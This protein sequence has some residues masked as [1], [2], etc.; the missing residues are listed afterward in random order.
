MS[1]L[2]C[3]NFF[4]LQPRDKVTDKSST[5]RTDRLLND[6]AVTLA[7]DNISLIRPSPDIENK[8][9]NSDRKRQPA[10]NKNSPYKRSYEKYLDQINEMDHIVRDQDVQL[11]DSSSGGSNGKDTVVGW[12]TTEESSE[13]ETTASESGTMCLQ[14]HYVGG[15]SDQDV[16]SVAEAY[17]RVKGSLPEGKSSLTF[18]FNYQPLKIP[19]GHPTIIGNNVQHAKEAKRFFGGDNAKLH[20]NSHN[21]TGATFANTTIQLFRPSPKLSEFTNIETNSSYVVDKL[22]KTPETVDEETNVVEKRSN[23]DSEQL[24]LCL[25]HPDFQE[26]QTNDTFIFDDFK[27]TQKVKA[28]EDVL[29]LKTS[30][31]RLVRQEDGNLR[32]ENCHVV[33]MEFSSDNQISPDVKSGNEFCFTVDSRNFEK[34]FINYSRE[35]KCISKKACLIAP[36]S[37]KM[38]NSGGITSGVVV[39]PH[40]NERS[41]SCKEVKN[42]SRG[43]LKQEACDVESK[44][45][46]SSRH[47]AAGLCSL[48]TQPSIYS[49]KLHQDREKALT[50]R[51]YNIKDL[52]YVGGRKRE[53]TTLDDHQVNSIYTEEQLSSFSSS[54][55]ADQSQ[56][57][58]Q[59][60]RDDK[61]VT[62]TTNTERMGPKKDDLGNKERV[63]FGVSKELTQVSVSNS[64]KKVI[65]KSDFEVHDKITQEKNCHDR[66]GHDY[67]AIIEE[68]NVEHEHEDN[69]GQEQETT[70]D[71]GI[72][73]AV[74]RI[75]LSDISQEVKSRQE[76]NCS[77]GWRNCKRTEAEATYK[78][79]ERFNERRFDVMSNGNRTSE[80]YNMRTKEG[81]DS[82]SAVIISEEEVCEGKSSVAT[83]Y[84][85]NGIQK[86][87]KQKDVDFD[88]QFG[89]QKGDNRVVEMTAMDDFGV[90]H[91]KIQIEDVNLSDIV[92][93]MYSSQDLTAR[94]NGDVKNEDHVTNQQP[95]HFLDNINQSVNTWNKEDSCPTVHRNGLSGQGNLRKQKCYRLTGISK[96]DVVSKGS[97]LSQTTVEDCRSFD[98][99][100]PELGDCSNVSQADPGII[101]RSCFNWSQIES[102]QSN[103][104]D[105]DKTI[106]SSSNTCSVSHDLKESKLSVKGDL[107]HVDMET[108]SDEEHRPKLIDNVT[109]VVDEVSGAKPYSPSSPTVKS[110][111]Q[112][113]PQPKDSSPYS[114]SHPTNVSEGD[115][116][117][118]DLVKELSY[119][120]EVSAHGVSTSGDKE[121]IGCPFENSFPGNNA[122]DNERTIT[123]QEVRNN[124]SE[125][126]CESLVTVCSEKSKSGSLPS[127]PTV[128]DALDV[129]LPVGDVAPS[130]DRKIHFENESGDEKGISASRCNS[131]PI[132]INENSQKSLL[133]CPQRT[134][135][136]VVSKPKIV[137]ISATR[138][139]G[140]N[141][142][143]TVPSKN[144]NS[145]DE[146]IKSGDVNCVKIPIATTVENNPQNSSPE[147]KRPFA[148]NV[149][150][151]LHER[152]LCIFSSSQ[153]TSQATEAT[154]KDS[155]SMNKTGEG[156]EFNPN[157][158]SVVTPVTSEQIEKRRITSTSQD[159]LDKQDDFQSHERARKMIREGEIRNRKDEFDEE[160]VV[161]P[162]GQ[163][164][165]TPQPHCASPSRPDHKRSHEDVRDG[166]R[167]CK[168]PKKSLKLIIPSHQVSD[169]NATGTPPESESKDGSCAV[170]DLRFVS[171]RDGSKAG[172]LKEPLNVT[173]YVMATRPPTTVTTNSKTGLVSKKI[174][175]TRAK[176]LKKTTSH[177][178]T[179]ADLDS[180]SQQNSLPSSEVDNDASEDIV[181][182]HSSENREI[183]TP[184]DPLSSKNTVGEGNSISRSDSFKASNN[185]AS[186]SST[187]DSSH[188]QHNKHLLNSGESIRTGER[189]EKGTGLEPDQIALTM[190]RL[191]KKKEE[192]EQVNFF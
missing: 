111:D 75:G 148:S 192:I 81:K 91:K 189:R 182:V 92:E 185:H 18:G 129:N 14:G 24:N 32:V 116:D 159:D 31:I 41:I 61:L 136:T 161:R 82:V 144:D 133:S 26:I 101:D 22:E 48:F 15:N 96:A 59:P 166:P 78:D 117:K 138:S 155:L 54:K 9:R 157:C 23:K 170:T 16:D 38:L 28:N 12:Y 74:K 105:A 34:N 40:Q 44:A 57:I 183:L 137:Y 37:K 150:L 102:H 171:D 69:N 20:D 132:I 88:R 43:T 77:T 134:Q 191:R 103:L 4:F 123:A 154:F 68:C 73:D 36:R 47:D 140:I 121:I 151:E 86:R 178:V 107:E 142:H 118:N 112:C 176:I 13:G 70:P 145:V 149:S 181:T 50:Q 67:K 169:G 55:V 1:Y 49:N 46:D 106:S 122:G 130:G 29:P 114:P 79:E 100:V 42:A 109:C 93:K 164:V 104:D 17:D 124:S 5:K 179:R 56:Q 126:C 146:A 52:N 172:L 139:K 60:V 21:A 115:L 30:G 184:L 7:G 119:H 158:D 131:S 80:V 11:V 10:D 53:K 84:D 2:F 175:K 163:S 147:S 8:H 174:T 87:S 64:K 39:S 99:S 71:E 62:E 19:P 45:A 152:S 66:N 85:N 33:D 76:I 141:A 6:L 186:S 165:L 143:E 153:G 65:L 128:E 180:V 25:K 167:P 72:D 110:D 51:S 190:E 120:E 89:G 177:T 135:S 113:S 125:V 35:D 63:T 188:Y 160:S 173:G 168:V 95:I 162:S 94:S 108:S 97:G 3:F 58:K 156:A 27:K 83:C 98:A 90:K 187:K 127:I